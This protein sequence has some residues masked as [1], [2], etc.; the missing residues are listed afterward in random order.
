MKRPDEIA[1]QGSEHAHQQ[2]I[3]Q[4]A[5]VAMWLGFDAAWDE[6]IYKRQLPLKGLP[7]KVVP[8]LTLLHA[9]H[10]QGH[11][12]AIRGAR[13]RA[14]GVKAGIPDIFLPVPR[15]TSRAEFHGLYIELKRPMYRNH[16]DGGLSED[17]AGLIELL[18]AHCYAVVVAYGWVEACQAIEGYLVNGSVNSAR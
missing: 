1:S 14:E 2:A 6:D 5:N 7:S 8:A 12:D 11:G 9:V 3:F 13:A 18:R 16:A 4:W 15:R 17:Q 10:N